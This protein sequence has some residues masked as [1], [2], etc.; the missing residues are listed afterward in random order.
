MSRKGPRRP[1]SRRPTGA[2]PESSIR[3]SIRGIRPPRSGS[4]RSRRPT[5]CSGTT[6]RGGPTTVSGMRA[7]APDSTPAGREVPDSAASEAAAG[8]RASVAAGARSRGSTSRRGD[9][10]DLFGNLFGGGPSRPGGAPGRR[11]AAG[12]DRGPVPRRRPRRDRFALAE[13]GADL[14]DVQRNRAHGQDP[15]CDVSRR[16]HRRGI[17]AR[18]HQDPGGHRGRRHDPRAGQGRTR[19]Q[20]RSG[21]RPLRHGSRRAACVLR[22]AGQRHP[23]DRPRHREGGV[24]RSG[25]RRADDSRN[26]ARE[27]PAG[28]AGAPALPAPQQGRQGS[29]HG[30]RGRS[31]LLGPRDDSRNSSTRA[32]EDAATLLDGLYEGDVRADLPKGL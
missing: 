32:G 3:T 4:R 15:M 7:P 14:P 10:G 28:H 25:D 26:D 20:R 12:A 16:G 19:R 6:R 21:R 29:A 13:T 27:D 2:W 30:R 22:A 11:G 23:R 9:L 5:R 17:R 8:G 24:R 1:T 31:H 18:A